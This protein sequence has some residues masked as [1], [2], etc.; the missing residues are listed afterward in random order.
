MPIISVNVEDLKRMVGRSIPDKEL[1]SIMPVMKM[2]IEEWGEEAKIEV[3]PDRPDLFSAEGMARQISSWLGITPGLQKFDVSKPRVEMKTTKVSLR[4]FITCGIVRNLKMSDSMVKSVMQLQ[5]TLD[6]TLGRDRKK[7]AIGI[8]DVSKVVPPFFYKEVLPEEI[9]FIP[10]NSNKRMNLKEIIETHPKGIQ[11]S[12]LVLG[13]KKW[14]IIVDSKNQVLSFPPIINGELTRVTEDTT[15]LFIDITGPEERTINY[16]L[17][18]LVTALEKRGGKIEAVSI[19]GKLRPD[20]SPRLIK[21]ETSNVRKLLGIEISNKEI[22]NLIERMGYGVTLKSNTADILIPPFRADI[23]HPVDITEDIAIAYGLNDFIP[24]IPKLPFT[25][26]SDEIEDFSQKIRELMIGLGFQEVLNF[27]LTSKEKQFEKMCIKYE[28]VVEIE[29][30]VSKEYSICRKW[31]LPS[32]LE[33][34]R[35]NKHRRFPQRIF[36]ISDCVI[37]DRKSEVMASNVRKLCCLITH[38]KANLSEILSILNAI[39]ENLKAKWNVTTSK[40]KSFTAGRCGSIILS[41]REIGVFGE[42]HPSV[43]V[44][45][46]LNNPVAA[47]EINVQQIFEN[48]KTLS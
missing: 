26:G 36:E 29:N 22:Q 25:G 45:F 20:L 2:N 8:H 19:D 32:L 43:I 10:L 15:D 34:C 28:D 1:E 41:G 6:L 23:M 24:E 12:H 48:L 47:L 5:E 35:S 27:T 21:I 11:Y 17:N 31:L 37:P 33:N 14:P 16:C 18:I 42:I 44:N 46:E 38:S 9:S 40:H 39:Q 13:A 7:V 3:T 4:P 30:P